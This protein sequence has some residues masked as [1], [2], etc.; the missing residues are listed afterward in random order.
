MYSGIRITR[1]KSPRKSF[2]GTGTHLVTPSILIM[3]SNQKFFAALLVLGTLSL[4]LPQEGLQGQERE[5]SERSDRSRNFDAMRYVKRADRN[6]DGVLDQ[7]ELGGRLKDYVTKLGVDTSR[8]VA[9]AKVQ[10]ALDDKAAKESEE[11][12]YRNIDANRKVPKFGES[13]E[14][15]PPPDFSPAEPE[16]DGKS[17]EDDYDKSTVESVQAYIRR[18]DKDKDGVLST[19]E[20]ERVR[21]WLGDTVDADKNGSISAKELAA[22]MKK[23]SD[24]EGSD[25]GD[26]RRGS[27]DR[28]SSERDRGS[29]SRDRGSSS[30]DRGSSSRDQNESRSREGSRDFRGRSSSSSKNSSTSKSSSS[31]KK[32]TR[33]MTGRYSSFVDGMLRKYDEDGDGKLNKDERKKVSGSTPL[34]D[35]NGD[36]MV[37]RGELLNSIEGRAKPA[38]AS[39]STASKRPTRRRSSRTSEKEESDTREESRETRSRPSRSRSNSSTEKSITYDIKGFEKITLDFEKRADRETYLKRQGASRDFLEW[40]KNADG[41][42]TMGEIRRGKKWTNELAQKFKKLDSNDDR[43]VTITEFDENFNSRDFDE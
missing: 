38:A 23:R 43:V 16:E 7:Q 35:E 19:K 6:E 5:R 29:S 17:W 40:D 33:S 1:S 11:E 12:R 2:R 31:S 20:S 3:T 21:R 4:L 9:I 24:R 25:R 36:G 42:I 18:D 30:R 41:Q 26:R 14:L 13:Q 37:D 27:S 22:G 10:K 39:K 8:P 28:R 15:L 32:S 34:V